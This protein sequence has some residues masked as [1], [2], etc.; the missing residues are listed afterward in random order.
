MTE[1][2]AFF[3]CEPRTLVTGRTRL[4]WSTY[5]NFNNRFFD[6]LTVRSSAR[7]SVA[8]KFGDLVILALPITPESVSVEVSANGEVLGHGLVI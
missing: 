6:A 3:G 5:G 2:A 4:V 7:R 8:H 1:L